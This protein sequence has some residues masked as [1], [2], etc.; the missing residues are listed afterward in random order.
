MKAINV[1][2]KIKQWALGVFIVNKPIIYFKCP[3]IKS[4]CTEYD[5]GSATLFTDCR[6]CI[7]YDKGIVASKF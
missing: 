6:D 2:N 1:F 7:H 4:E 3:Y 5:S